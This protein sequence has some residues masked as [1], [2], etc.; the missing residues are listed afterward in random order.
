[1]KLTFAMLLILLALSIAVGNAEPPAGADRSLAPWFHSLR[2]P[3]TG[4]SC[5]D[6]ADCRNYPVAVS[7]AGY[8]VEFEGKWLKVPADVVQERADN[9]TGAYVACVNPRHYEEGEI[10]PV[11]L[12]FFK[13][14]GT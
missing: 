13:A 4:G 1:M 12:C 14:P 9:P 8:S 10:A 2:V 11:V 3:S 5:C 6:E 7:S